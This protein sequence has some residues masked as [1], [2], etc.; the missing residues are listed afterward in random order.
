MYSY[1]L[2]WLLWTYL[3]C[4]HFHEKKRFFPKNLKFSNFEIFFEKS[5]IFKK[6]IKFQIALKTSLFELW[7]NQKN[8]NEN[9]WQTI[10]SLKKNLAR[11]HLRA[12][13]TPNLISFWKLKNHQNLVQ[14]AEYSTVARAEVRARQKFFYHRI[15]HK[16]LH[17]PDTLDVFIS[18]KLIAVDG[19]EVGARRCTCEHHFV[20]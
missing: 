14:K 13:R 16:I 17:L 3:K 2:N 18:L 6:I 15:L 4:M 5:W 1:L 12:R 19:F 11:A 9:F 10:H 7:T 8:C 20:K